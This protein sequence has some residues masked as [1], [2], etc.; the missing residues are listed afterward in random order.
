MARSNKL[1]VDESDRRHNKSCQ[2][3]TP[4]IRKSSRKENFEGATAKEAMG[5][6][7]SGRQHD[8]LSDH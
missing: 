1:S 7:N 8:G 3:G 5:K 2:T 6:E 4:G